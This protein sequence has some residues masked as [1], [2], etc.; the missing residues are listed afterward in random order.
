LH[1]AIDEDGEIV[2]F[3]FANGSRHDVKE[4]ENFCSEAA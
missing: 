4:V 3:R 2:A 1:I